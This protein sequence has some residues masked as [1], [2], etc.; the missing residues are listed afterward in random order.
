MRPSRVQRAVFYEK[1]K[2]RLIELA[3]LRSSDFD[4]LG[5][6]AVEDLG[7][8][9]NPE[10]LAA[11]TKLAIEARFVPAQIKE[12]SRQVRSKATDAQMTAV[13]EKWR[14]EN[15]AR[16]KETSA[17]RISPPISRLTKSKLFAARVASEMGAQLTKGLSRLERAEALRFLKKF[18]AE[19]DTMIRRLEGNH[20]APARPS[21]VTARAN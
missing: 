12:F 1:T 3:G 2:D 11:M 10:I 16:I 18:R 14:T 5:R 17:G 6:Q 7:K 20:Q 15:A 19:I 8:V 21:R 9:N 13:V 4:R